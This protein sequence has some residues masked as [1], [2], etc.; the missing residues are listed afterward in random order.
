MNKICIQFLTAIYNRSNLNIKEGGKMSPFFSRVFL[1]T[2]RHMISQGWDADTAYPNSGGRKGR[3]EGQCYVTSRLLKEL[4]VFGKVAIGKVGNYE[5]LHCWYE[6]EI[7]GET[8]II[9]L[10][11]D[12]RGIDKEPIVVGPLADFPDYKRSGYVTDEEARASKSKAFERYLL[13][14]QRFLRQ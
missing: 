1:A 5:G 10:T 3:P 12:Q 9:D 7:N 4:H 11:A 2:L 8:W 6:N 14:K 13:L